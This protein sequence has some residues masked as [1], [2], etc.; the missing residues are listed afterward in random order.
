MMT[1]QEYEKHLK[2]CTI[3]DL[4]SIIHGIDRE[5]FPERFQMAISEKESRSIAGEIEFKDDENRFWAKNV[6]VKV[7]LS[8][9]WLITWRSTIAYLLVVLPVITM[10]KKYASAT[11]AT[12]HKLLV[13]SSLISFALSSIF[14]VFFTRQAIANQYKRFELQIKPLNS[15]NKAI[16]P[17]LLRGGT[18]G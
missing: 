9:W 11:G 8:V 6:P 13:V 15:S 16:V 4:D 14:G 5:R 1:D 3:R 10:Y 18:N 2:A 12:Q 17:N 7:G